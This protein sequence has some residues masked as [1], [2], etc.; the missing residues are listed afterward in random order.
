MSRALAASAT[1]C[2]SSPISGAI[3]ISWCASLS[4]ASDEARLITY[5]SRRNGATRSAFAG[6][7]PWP[8]CGRERRT[9][10]CVSRAVLLR[11]CLCPATA[12]HR[13]LGASV[14][15]AYEHGARCVVPKT[16]RVTGVVDG[17]IRKPLVRR[18]RYE[19]KYQTNREVMVPA[20]PM[21]MTSET[22]TLNEKAM[23]P[24]AMARPTTPEHVKEAHRRN[25][26]PRP[27][28]SAEPCAV[29]R[30]IAF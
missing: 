15:G 20:P 8:T 25:K 7:R 16:R 23:T 4:A 13:M 27:R 28:S 11:Q 17:R 9:W 14:L 3:S 10:R 18:I 24:V 6:S 26:V 2:T 22:E 1:C 19:R 5:F 29:R 30:A 21:P 12:Q